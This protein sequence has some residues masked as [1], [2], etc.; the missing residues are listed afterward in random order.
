[1]QERPPS[2][3][4]FFNYMGLM[5]V[6]LALRTDVVKSP[7]IENIKALWFTFAYIF[8]LGILTA[9]VLMIVEDFYFKHIQKKIFKND[10][11]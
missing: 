7:T 5:W 6:I 10:R 8:P 2:L 4:R 3:Q 9:L 11:S 1:M